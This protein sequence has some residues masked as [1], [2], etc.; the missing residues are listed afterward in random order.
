MADTWDV[1]I[2]QVDVLYMQSIHG[3]GACPPLHD[4][5]DIKSFFVFDKLGFVFSS[6]YFKHGAV[7]PFQ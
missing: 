6:I 5:I 1:A 3:N 2:G 7:F 4:V